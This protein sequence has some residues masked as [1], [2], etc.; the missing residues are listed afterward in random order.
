MLRIHIYR[1]YPHNIPK[2]SFDII[3]ITNDELLKTNKLK[4]KANRQHQL[5]VNEKKHAN[6]TASEVTT[7]WI[8][9][10]YS[11]IQISA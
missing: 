11:L 10:K 6:F 7:L 1:K 3:I 5:S 8:V 9:A 2:V 4:P